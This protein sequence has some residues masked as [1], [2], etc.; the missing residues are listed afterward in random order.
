MAVILRDT[1]VLQE[2]KFRRDIVREFG[3]KMPHFHVSYIESHQTTPGIPDLHLYSLVSG[4]IWLE[5]KVVKAP[6]DIVMV[7]PTQKAWHRNRH[8]AG[9]KSWFA[10][11]DTND[12]ILLTP[13]NVAAGLPTR[14]AA[15]RDVSPAYRMSDLKL[16]IGAMK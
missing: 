11:L 14:A 15:W 12:H 13:G 7:R 8:K 2:D 3:M 1:E 5:L 4:D 9:G 16:M 6:R 10:T